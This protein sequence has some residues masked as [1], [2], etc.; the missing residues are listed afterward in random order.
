MIKTY[1]KNLQGLPKEKKLVLTIIEENSLLLWKGTEI[2]QAS[3]LHYS[4]NIFLYI[5]GNVNT[6]KL[7]LL[8]H[9]FNRAYMYCAISFEIN[10]MTRKLVP[11]FALEYLLVFCIFC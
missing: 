4:F 5:L 2:L 1:N 7:P 6:Y 11:W 3:V 10:K 8:M 9:T